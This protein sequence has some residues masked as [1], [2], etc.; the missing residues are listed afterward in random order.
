MTGQGSKVVIIVSGQG[1]KPALVVTSLFW[2][3]QGKACRLFWSLQS[4]GIKYVDCCGR[5]RAR[6]GDGYGRYE[7]VEGVKAVTGDVFSFHPNQSTIP[8]GT[9]TL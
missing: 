4:T 3:L 7:G 2:S 8:T 6:C 1:V 5:Y 9:S